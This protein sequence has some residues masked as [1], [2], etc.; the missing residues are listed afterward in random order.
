VTGPGPAPESDV[1]ALPAA[2][3][4][5]QAWLRRHLGWQVTGADPI[6][7][8]SIS[9]SGGLMGAVD[10]IECAGHSMVF[11]TPP[12]VLGE[13]GAFAASTGL[14]EREVLVYR[15]LSRHAAARP[16]V[17]PR[18]LWS[19]LRADHTGALALENLGPPAAPE[20]LMARGLSRVQ[21]TAAVRTLAVVHSMAAVVGER[22]PGTAHPCQEAYPWLLTAGSPHLVEAVR[23]GIDSLGRLVA[24]HWPHGL[25]GT[26]PCLPSLGA[27]DVPAVLIRAH[28]TAT[29][30]TLCHGDVWAGNLLFRPPRPAS[31]QP[32]A[33]LVDW[34]F[35]MW[36]NPLYDV[37]LLLLS[38]LPTAR[39]RD[40]QDDLLVAYHRTLTAHCDVGY[41]LADCR[42][43]FALALPAAAVVALATVEAYT[44][45]MTD[46]QL[47]D[48]AD[49]VV[50]A[51]GLA[52]ARFAASPDTG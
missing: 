28:A 39:R 12:Q 34:Q 19:T 46:G 16:A 7:R 37:A 21:A 13:W 9:Q 3:G 52:G 44:S 36:G 23:I 15:L 2:A 41:S 45:G 38:S 47:R 24:L 8:R 10:L 14:I 48:V 18:L 25:P 6:V 20:A 26:G 32:R 40:W 1:D 51:L 5:D 42:R 43:D 29:C 11:K 22:G 50:A 31:T 17:A 27:V 4:I 35:A 30:A 49:R 33:F